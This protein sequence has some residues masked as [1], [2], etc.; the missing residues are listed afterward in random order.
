MVAVPHP[1]RKLFRSVG[2]ETV[3][4]WCGKAF[5][6]R[7]RGKSFKIPD[8]SVLCKHIATDCCHGSNTHILRVA[9][10]SR[11]EA[12]DFLERQAELSPGFRWPIL[13]S[14]RSRSTSPFA[15]TRRTHTT[16][17]LIHRSRSASPTANGSDSL[18]YSGHVADNTFSRH[19][20]RAHSHAPSAMTLADLMSTSTAPNSSDLLQSPNSVSLQAM[21]SSNL[22]LSPR[23]SHDLIPNSLLNLAALGDPPE[24]APLSRSTAGPGPAAPS[25]FNSLSSTSHSSSSGAASSPHNDHGAHQTAPAASHILNPAIPN[26]NLPIDPLP[27]PDQLSSRPAVA[28]LTSPP[29]HWAETNPPHVTRPRLETSSTFSTSHG[30]LVSSSLDAGYSNASSAALPPASTPLNANHASLKSQPSAS[31]REHRRMMGLLTGEFRAPNVGDKMVYLTNDNGKL[32][33]CWKY[34]DKESWRSALPYDAEDHQTLQL[35]LAELAVQLGVKFPDLLHTDAVHKIAALIH[36][37]SRV[38]THQRLRIQALLPNTP[39]LAL[40]PLPPSASPPPGPTW[41]NLATNGWNEPQAPP[42][43]GHSLPPPAMIPMAAGPL[44]SIGMMDPPLPHSSAKPVEPVTVPGTNGVHN[45][46]LTTT[47]APTHTVGQVL[48]TVETTRPYARPRRR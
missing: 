31:A 25:T 26:A 32:I 44:P 33:T 47:T 29:G 10:V 48:V 18:R 1:L 9:V 23:M 4:L 35:L 5:K 19:Q 46:P 12:E 6:Y 43:S 15:Q 2:K 24:T 3:C 14:S 45:G 28:T 38:D 21:G 13:P 8:I 30:P 40:S 34:A 20:T 36:P 11:S 22:T 16:D 27:P 7:P 17:H 41:L 37:Q 42:T 39:S